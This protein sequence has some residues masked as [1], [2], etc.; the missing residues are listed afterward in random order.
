MLTIKAV[1]VGEFSLLS[2]LSLATVYRLS[3]RRNPSPAALAAL[4]GLS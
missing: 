4:T 2:V 3:A 1:L